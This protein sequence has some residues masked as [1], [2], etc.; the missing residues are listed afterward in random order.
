MSENTTNQPSAPTLP[1]WTHLTTLPDLSRVNEAWGRVG[2][3]V[4]HA[5]ELY[6]KE[7]TAYMT[8]TRNVQREILGQ[9]LSTTQELSRMGERQLAFLVR[10][11][12]NTPVPGAVPKGT[13]T[14]T[15]MVEGVV[16]ETTHGA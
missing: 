3:A 7:L 4:N 12:E 11:R 2:D 9:A 14:I 8:W 5:S 1:N 10:L 13:E 6:L 15:G 16:K